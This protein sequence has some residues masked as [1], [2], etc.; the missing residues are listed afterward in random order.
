MM[1]KFRGEMR[2]WNREQSTGVR[3]ETVW[4]SRKPQREQSRL[5]TPE[6]NMLLLSLQ[7]RCWFPLNYNWK[8]KWLTSAQVQFAFFFEC[9]VE[10]SHF[11]ENE[12]QKCLFYIGLQEVNG[13][14]ITVKNSLGIFVKC[15]QYCV[16]VLQYIMG[17]CFGLHPDFAAKLWSVRSLS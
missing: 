2:V 4:F 5:I 11:Y 14:M 13:Q 15:S 17:K 6:P 16:F 3:G 12:S 9:P 8:R 10:K 1:W 7:A